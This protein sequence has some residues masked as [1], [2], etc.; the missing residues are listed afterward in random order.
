MRMQVSGFLAFRVDAWGKMKSKRVGS[1]G[2]QRHTI[3]MPPLLAATP[4]KGIDV[5]TYVCRTSQS[6]SSR[7]CYTMYDCVKTNTSNPESANNR[8]KNAF[9]RHRLSLDDASI[10]YQHTRSFGHRLWFRSA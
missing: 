3:I 8:N 9:I 6:K 5:A 2:T 7:R 1:L 10:V 4:M